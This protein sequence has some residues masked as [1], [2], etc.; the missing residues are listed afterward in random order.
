M[1][2]PRVAVPRGAVWLGTFVGAVVRLLR[3]PQLSPEEREE[4]ER[5]GEA[6]RVRA[7]ADRHRNTD[8]GFAADLHAAAA[9]YE[10]A[11]EE[12]ASSL[13]RAKR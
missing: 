7:L 4:R 10:Q 3:P 11:F 13:R 1:V 6:A 5:A 2:P 12:A 9:R 8:P